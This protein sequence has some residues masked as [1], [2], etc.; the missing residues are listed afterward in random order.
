MTK[1]PDY[2]PGIKHHKSTEISQHQQATYIT[3][4]TPWCS[5]SNSPA[6]RAQVATIGGA[7]LLK[8][9]GDIKN[10]ALPP[11]FRPADR[12]DQ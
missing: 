10:C 12:A 4:A 7:N 1:C 5:D 11:E 2:N 6:T 3:S 8:C 9:G